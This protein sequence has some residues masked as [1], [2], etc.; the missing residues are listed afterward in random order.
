M[1]GF[2]IS[3]FPGSCLVPH[4]RAPSREYLFIFNMR[5]GHIKA[6]TSKDGRTDLEGAGSVKYS[7][8]AFKLSYSILY[9]SINDRYGWFSKCGVWL[10]SRFRP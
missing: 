3:F 6:K 4:A 10:V 8:Y 5:N 7:R 9:G 2:D 1:R